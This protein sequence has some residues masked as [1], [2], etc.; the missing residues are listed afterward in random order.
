MT[1]DTKKA[2]L[3]VHRLLPSWESDAQVRCVQ[4][5][6]PGEIVGCDPDVVFKSSDPDSSGASKYLAC[7]VGRP[8]D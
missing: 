4:V 3:I 8:V 6:P 7:G 1:G 5:V 2:N